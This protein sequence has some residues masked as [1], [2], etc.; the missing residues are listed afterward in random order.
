MILDQYW[1]RNCVAGCAHEEYVF[2][3]DRECMDAPQFLPS[4]SMKRGESEG[5]VTLFTEMID[6]DLP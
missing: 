2:M 1:V 3:E 4:G 6:R 5:Q